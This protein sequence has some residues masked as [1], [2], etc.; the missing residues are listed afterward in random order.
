MLKDAG[1]KKNFNILGLVKSSLERAKAIP[2]HHVIFN[3]DDTKEARVKSQTSDDVWYSL[4][5][6]DCEWACCNC[7]WAMKGNICKH[8]LKVMMMNGLHENKV[9][10]KSMNMFVESIEADTGECL[11]Y[12][13]LHIIF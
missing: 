9:V 1:F 3:D 6:V 10:Q 13:M 5:N 2:D 8:Q 7:E 4:H 11:L 12:K